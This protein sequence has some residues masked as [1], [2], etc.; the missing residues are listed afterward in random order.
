MTDPYVPERGDDRYRVDHYDLELDYA[1][2]SNRLRGRARLAVTATTAT[3]ALRVDLVGLRVSKVAAGGQPARWR[4][5]AGALDVT[6][7]AA[8][9]AGERT[10]LDI[11]YGGS[12]HPTR[13]TWGEVGWEE[14]EDGVL[15]AG[16]PNGAPTWFPCND[17]AAQK[18]GFRTSVT[19]RAPYVVL[20]NGV[21]T[22]RR[23]GAGTTTWV[24]EQREPTSPYL[25]T[26][27][28]GRYDEI[29]QR[30]GEVPLRALVAHGQREAFDGAF[31][32]QPE[33]LDVFV[34]LFGPYPVAAGHTVVVTADPLEVPLEAQGQAVFGSNHLDGS[35]ERLI[36]HELAHAW[37][38]NSVTAASWRDIWLHEGFACYAE[39]LWSER[40]GGRSAARHAAHHHQ[41]LCELPQDL[42]L[43]DPGPRD[44]FDDRVYKRGALALHALRTHLGDGPFFALLRRWT[45][46]HRHATATTAEFAALAAVVAGAPVHDV[47]SPWLD[48]RA[49]PAPP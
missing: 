3:A 39:W 23:T 44:M 41:R 8:L 25:M 48:Q 10:T 32:R 26:C 15:V 14:L 37:F 16:Q 17:Q 22:E 20:V 24:Y 6:L 40:S 9:A 27:N 19:A 31:A 33:M 29:T 34:E 11:V 21:R 42:L 1:V 36:A 13:S 2:T 43:T 4:Q 12:P 47:L 18:A 38:G 30:G 28:I 7:P 35:W 46:E 49:L 5:R 45:D